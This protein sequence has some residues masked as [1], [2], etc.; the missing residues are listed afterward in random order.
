MGRKQDINTGASAACF[1]A[2][3]IVGL[4]MQ[5]LWGGVITFVVLVGL[6]VVLRIIR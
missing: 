3:A 2:A 1:V 4:M 6:L 5:S